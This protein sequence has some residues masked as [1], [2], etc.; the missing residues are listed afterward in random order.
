V[1]TKVYGQGT[2]II[3]YNAINDIVAPLY[4]KC[5]CGLSGGLIKKIYGRKDISL[6]SNDN[7]IVLPS[8]FGEIFSKILYELK[9]NKLKNVRI[10]QHSL[11]KIEIQVVIDENL[12]E[13]GPSVE[14]IFSVIEDGF[15]EKIGKDVEFV[16]KEVK[17]IDKSRPRIISK[18]DPSKIKIVGYD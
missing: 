9:T 10:I 8:S 11:S 3:R 15:K 5:E 2:P 1:I 18:V 4:E 13:K 14:K 12:R 6:I 17:N 16:T 7:K